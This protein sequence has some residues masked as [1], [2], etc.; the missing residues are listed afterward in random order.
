MVDFFAEAVLCRGLSGVGLV[1]LWRRALR[2]C[3]GYVAQVG[4]S[5]G[6]RAVVLQVVFDV[7]FVFLFVSDKFVITLPAGMIGSGGDPS[8]SSASTWESARG[9]ATYLTT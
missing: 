4:I 8:S 6:H 5:C 1:L 7:L 9:S 2:G 3:R